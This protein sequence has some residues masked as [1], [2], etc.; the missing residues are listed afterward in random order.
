M[1]PPGSEACASRR[2][3]NGKAPDSRSKPKA[4][5]LLKG[6]QIR[7]EIMNVLVRI[8]AQ[9]ILMSSQRVLY[10]YLDLRKRPGPIRSLR[11]LDRHIECIQVKELAFRLLARG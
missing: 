10:I 3:E 6:F 2:R 8:F 7:E 5:A 1:L 9:Q 4:A 11:I